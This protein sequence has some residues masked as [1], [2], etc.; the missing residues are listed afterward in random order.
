MKPR[1]IRDS[2]WKRHKH[3]DLQKQRFHIIIFGKMELKYQPLSS[4]VA[5]TS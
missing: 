4:I 1:S 2:S 5:T 3:D